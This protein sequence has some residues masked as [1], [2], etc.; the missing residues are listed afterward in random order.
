[1]R[2]TPADPDHPFTYMR[3]EPGPAAPRRTLLT[4]KLA[5]PRSLKDSWTFSRAGCPVGPPV[6]PAAANG[7]SPVA[8]APG[9]LAELEE[10]LSRP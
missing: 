10:L 8:A 3:E 6:R 5:P 9:H 4:P 2:P 1:M 7:Q